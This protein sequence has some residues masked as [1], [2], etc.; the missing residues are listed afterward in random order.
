MFSRIGILGT[1][2]YVDFLSF[3]KKENDI[4]K[5]NRSKFAISSNSAQ[6][7]LQLKNDIRNKHIFV[8][9]ATVISLFC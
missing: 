5:G 7:T 9:N 3:I 6:T 1:N 8:L 4:T 2:D